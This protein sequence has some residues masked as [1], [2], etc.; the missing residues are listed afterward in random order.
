MRRPVPV[1]STAAA[2][3]LRARWAKAFIASDEADL[4]FANAS[5]NPRRVACLDVWLLF[6]LAH[7]LLSLDHPAFD[8]LALCSP[9][10][11]EFR[12]AEQIGRVVN[13]AR[14]A[15]RGE[16]FVLTRVRTGRRNTRAAHPKPSRRLSLTTV[17]DRRR[18]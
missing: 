7:R 11:R 14:E 2:A 13:R 10:Y 18:F 9:C 16:S 12:G 17:T 1:L 15:H 4:L 3:R 6:A 8:H 5:P